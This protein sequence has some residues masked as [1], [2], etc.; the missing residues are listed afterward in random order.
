MIKKRS[1]K[2]YLSL[3]QLIKYWIEQSIDEALT[4]AVWVLAWGLLEPYI[5]NMPIMVRWLIIVLLIIIL[6]HDILKLYQ[7]RKKRRKKKK[8]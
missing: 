7:P 4:I 8:V 5:I 3:F 2:K 1:K 6:Q